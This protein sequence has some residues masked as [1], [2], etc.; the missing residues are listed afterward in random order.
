MNSSKKMVT[1]RRVWAGRGLGVGFKEQRDNRCELNV[2]DE[3]ESSWHREKPSTVIV[4]D[5]A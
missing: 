4:N 5:G 1:V 3:E 2:I